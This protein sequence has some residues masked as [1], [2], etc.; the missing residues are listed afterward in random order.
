MNDYKTLMNDYKTLMNNYKTL[1]K[2][3][4]ELKD[5]ISFLIDDRKNFLLNK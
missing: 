4:E 3:D 5:N 1:K 2:Y